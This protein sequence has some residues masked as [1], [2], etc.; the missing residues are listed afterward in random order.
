MNVVDMM[1]L[2]RFEVGLASYPSGWNMGSSL[3]REE[4]EVREAKIIQ[5]RALK[6]I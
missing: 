2:A 5:F 6:R 1:K 4:G 3:Q